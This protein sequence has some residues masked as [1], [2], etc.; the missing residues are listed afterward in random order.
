MEHRGSQS[1]DLSSETNWDD[2]ISQMQIKTKFY[3]IGSYPYKLT[4]K[5]KQLRFEKKINKHLFQNKTML[6][7]LYSHDMQSNVCC[8]DAE[9]PFFL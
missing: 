5:T 3:K 1:N 7:I 6:R 8:F 2:S 9:H 4:H